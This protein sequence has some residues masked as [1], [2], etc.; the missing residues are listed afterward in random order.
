MGSMALDL[1]TM[2]HALQELSR[3]YLGDCR[4]R[5]VNDHQKRFLEWCVQNRAALESFDRLE[6]RA[7]LSFE[8]LNAFLVERGFAP[9]FTPFQG[10]GVVSILDMVME[11]LVKGTIT[12]IE[13][14]RTSYPAF[15]IPSEG[16]HVFEHGGEHPL[17]RL[18][19]K[20]GE[21]LWLMTAP[22]PDSELEL[23]FE[24]ERLLARSHS[25]SERWTAGV[26]VPMLEMEFRTDLSW[27][28]GMHTVDQDGGYHELTQAFQQFKL[29]A[30]AEGAHVL[31]A[32]GM[33]T[34]R[35]GFSTPQPYRFTE[36]F[37]GFFTDA[38]DDFVPRAAFWADTD[39][40]K[41]SSGTL[42]II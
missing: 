1:A 8:E 3:I 22:K 28:L 17:I 27:L 31:V 2:G 34:T 26:V 20:S 10:V 14:E 30:G 40:W 29:K 13:R 24:A 12:T 4:W 42:R 36:P 19:T 15:R 21:G 32:T 23:A 6:A 35:G 9:M 39:S 7:S 33:A 5:D 25:F 11:W 41:N 16:V 18:L 37:M 38:Q